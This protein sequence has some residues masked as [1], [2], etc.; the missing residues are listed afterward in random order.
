[1]VSSSIKATKDLFQVSQLM[2]VL[3]ED[4]PGDLSTALEALQSRGKAWVKRYEKGL[5]KLSDTY[6]ETYSLYKSYFS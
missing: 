3:L 5:K 1:L 6:P 2:K 4:R